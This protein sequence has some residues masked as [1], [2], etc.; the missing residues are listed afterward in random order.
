[1]VLALRVMKDIRV[2]GV[3]SSVVNE[4][5]RGQVCGW[6]VLALRPRVATAWSCES[7]LYWRSQ[8]V[9]GARAMGY[10]PRTAADRSGT[11]KREVFC[12]QHNWKGRA[13]KAF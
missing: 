3:G 2:K 1:M 11:K 9:G 12:S 5:C 8:D 10:L 6:E 4:S 7:E 13:T